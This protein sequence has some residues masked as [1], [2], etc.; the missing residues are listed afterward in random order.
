MRAGGGG[1][2]SFSPERWEVVVGIEPTSRETIHDPWPRTREVECMTRLSARLRWRVYPMLGRFRPD[3]GVDPG[4]YSRFRD[5]ELRRVGPR[6][7][8]TRYFNKFPGVD[9]F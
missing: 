6:M 1:P 7:A 4:P 5:P 2:P 8:R 9:G 3:L